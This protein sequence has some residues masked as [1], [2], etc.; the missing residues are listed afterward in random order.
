ME[1]L[2]KIVVTRLQ[3]PAAESHP[4][5]DLLTAF[6]EYSLAGAER[7]RV[8]EH[9]AR[10]GE[11]REVVSLALP[12]QVDLQPAAD[13]SGNWLRRAL[14]R[15][16]AL[17]WTAVAAGLALIASFGVMQY[18]RQRPTEFASNLS[19]PSPAI[20]A[21]QAQ[22]LPKANQAVPEAGTE[23]KN[24]N[25]EK[26]NDKKLNGKNLNEKLR[27]RIS[28]AAPATQIPASQ[29][30]KLPGQQVLIAAAPA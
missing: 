1:S 12:P 11:C 14:L 19:Q 6:A 15:G 29:P 28:S 7:E 23:T 24:L 18:R 13:T 3:S 27:T 17:R 22:A 25:D 10:C 9:L 8:T 16:S 21:P 30:E 2:P 20:D 5:A 4:D 26:L